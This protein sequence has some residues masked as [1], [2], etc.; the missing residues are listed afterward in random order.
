MTKPNT[1]SLLSFPVPPDIPSFGDCIARIAVD[2]TLAKE[3]RRDMISGLTRVAEVLTRAPDAVPVHVPWLQPRLEEVM[4][5]AL[6]LSAK[7]WANILSN[8]KAA[9][10]HL[11]FI[12]TGTK[13]AGALSPAWATHWQALR[14]SSESG[15]VPGLLGFVAY[16]DDQAVAPDGV[17]G[18]HLT[19]YLGFVATRSLR[20]NPLDVAR[21][22]RI[23][24]NRAA[25][26]VAG[27][28]NRQLAPIASDTVYCLPDSRFSGSFIA[29]V[30]ALMLS[31]A[32]PDP[33]A[34]GKLQ[35]AMRPDTVKAR[36]GQFTRFA[37]VLVH[38]GLPIERIK[39]IRDLVVPVNLERGLR[40]LLQRSNNTVTPGLSNM[41][42]ALRMLIRHHVTLSDEERARAEELCGKVIL[43][44]TFGL[45]EKN[46]KRLMPFNDGSLTDDFLS[47]PQKLW[48]TA[49]TCRNPTE[50]AR[51]RETAIALEIL[52]F[53][54]VR[55][56]NLA[57]IHVER[58]LQRHGP[59][60][61]VLNLQA[62][63]T[64]TGR[65]IS[66]VLP[67]HLVGWIDEH[68]RD[69]TGVLCPPG[70]SWLFPRRDG[71]MNMVPSSL[72]CRISEVIKRHMGLKV[73]PHLYRHLSAKLMLKANPGHYELVRRVLGHTE[74][75]T[76]WETYVG[77]EGEDA[78]R[79]LSEIV[80]QNRSAEVPRSKL[81][82]KTGTGGNLVP[83][84]AS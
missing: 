80:L 51:Q 71:T 44:R 77:L 70:V 35:R 34:P 21:R 6:G 31:L 41:A 24:W 47:L 37:A 1:A 69:R 81:A 40:W 73:H 8:M 64:K 25:K 28:P 43:P 17:G 20:K 27:W 63:Q 72:G 65:A 60:N 59:G 50:Q 42:V 54:P 19:D 61:I 79:L 48:T 29:E 33:L 76:T 62:D 46:R 75:S 78:T 36:R 5:K 39:A 68:L 45:T 55:R 84:R 38:A 83:L 7:T 56:K 74:T 2:T 15:L 53:C 82:R 18:G 67:D 22:A 14:Q 11:G 32:K 49:K 9:L 3:R 12:K 26:L 23:A 52:T 58:D 13:P 16:L 57:E 30:D 10:V 4:P 66:F